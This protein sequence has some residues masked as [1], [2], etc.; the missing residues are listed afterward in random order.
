LLCSHCQSSRGHYGDG[1]TCGYGSSVDAR[2]SEGHARQCCQL[3]GFV[4]LFCF[5]VCANDGR[6]LLEG[7]REGGVREGRKEVF[8]VLFCFVLS[9][10]CFVALFFLELFYRF[11]FLF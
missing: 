1:A 10:V 5:S 7:G 3:C 11:S 8:V 4:P 9:R 6:G 2:A